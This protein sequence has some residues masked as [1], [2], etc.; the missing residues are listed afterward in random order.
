MGLYE[1]NNS[2]DPYDEI[3][4]V[5]NWEIVDQHDHT[6]GRGVQIP[7]GGIAPG[8]VGPVQLAVTAPIVPTGGIIL[9]TNQVVPNG[10]LLC[11]GNAYAQVVYPALYAVIGTTYGTGSAGTFLVPNITSSPTLSVGSVSYIIRT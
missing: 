6:P 9:W 5:G 2:I 7:M 3:Q 4:L 1:W 8:A 11:N 10:F